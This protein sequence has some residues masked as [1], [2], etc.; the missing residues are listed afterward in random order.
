MLI[1]ALIGQSGAIAGDN[2]SNR[3]L[4]GPYSGIFS[5]VAVTSTFPRPFA[6]TGLFVSDGDGNLVGHETVS[7]NGHACDYQIEGTYTV[8]AD[9][10]GSDAIEFFNGAPG[11]GTGSYTQS[12][13]VADAGDLILLSNTNSPDVATEHWYRVKEAQNETMGACCLTL[14]PRTDCIVIQERFC[15][16]FKGSYKGDDTKCRAPI[17]G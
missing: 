2:A 12:L 7:F 10:T 16:G 6:G 14:R 8:A 15:N 13:A 3:L 5:G 9:G 11:C 1:F 4:R 17:C